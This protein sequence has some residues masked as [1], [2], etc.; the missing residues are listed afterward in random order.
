MDFEWNKNN[1]IE[2][3]KLAKEKRCSYRVGPELEIPGYTC[4]DHFLELDTLVHSWEVVGELLKGDLTENIIVDVGMPVMHKNVLYN[5]R[6]ILLN[7]QIIYV[8]PKTF[9][10]ND[11]NYREGRWFTPWKK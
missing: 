7:H 8:R 3:I 9:L 6:V 4:E 2:S 11:G 1:I 5:C 10:A